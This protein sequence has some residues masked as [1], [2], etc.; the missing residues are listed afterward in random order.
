[1][2]LVDVTKRYGVRV[3]LDHAHLDV[4]AGQL[5]A[6]LGPS[7]AGKTTLLDLLLGWEHP[8]EGAIRRA[9]A[10]EAGRDGLVPWSA[11]AVVPQQPGLLA[12]LS[13]GD[14][15]A[16]PLRLAGTADR[17]RFAAWTGALGLDE[18]LGRRPGQVS[19]GEEQR[20]SLARALVVEPAL[21]LADEPTAHQDEAGARAVLVALRQAVDRGAGCVVVTHDERVLDHADVVADV[22]AG[23]LRTRPAPSAPA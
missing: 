7:G 21:L 12:D 3:A 23:A 14:N 15:I 10:V 6:V 19:L 9:P 17:G 22:A 16:L 5:L 4:R 18:L 8:D 11:V 13:I 20:A 1:M 2:R